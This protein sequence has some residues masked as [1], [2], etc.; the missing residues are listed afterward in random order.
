[1][2]PETAI[3]ATRFRRE[4]HTLLRNLPPEGLIITKRGRPVA[5][6]IPIEMQ[7]EEM[8]GYLKGEIEIYGDI[9][10]TGITWDATKD[11]NE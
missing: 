7:P 1:M 5:R 11:P 8:I 4:F 6:L 9:Y 10:S 2:N 3:S